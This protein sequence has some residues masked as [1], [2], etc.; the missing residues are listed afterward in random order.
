MSKLSPITMRHLTH[1]AIIVR[2]NGGSWQYV[3]PFINVS[4]SPKLDLSS[5]FS[6]HRTPIAV[7]SHVFCFLEEVTLLPRVPI[8]WKHLFSHHDKVFEERHDVFQ[9]EMQPTRGEFIA[10]QWLLHSS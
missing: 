1:Q 6:T 9:T 8:A 7:V 3:V 10:S 5:F 2:R 4:I